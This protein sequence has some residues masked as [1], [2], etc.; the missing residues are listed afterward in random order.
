[1]GEAAPR[2]I[3]RCLTA[4]LVVFAHVMLVWIV[5]Q[6]RAPPM[7]HAEDATGPYVIA[8]L[9]DQPRPRNL[10]LG[11]TPIQVKTQ[12]VLHLQKLAPRVPDIPIDLSEPTIAE[13]TVPLPISSPTVQQSETGVAGEA[14]ES[15]A[16]SGG[17]HALTLIKRV[18]PKYPQASA[19]L[20]EQGNTA[21]RIRVDESGS[22]TDAKVTH[23]S[24]SRRLD[25]AA[26]AA[27]RKWKYAPS[28]R[29]SGPNGWWIQTELRFVLYQFTYSRI[30]DTAAE[31][32]YGEQVKAG[33]KDEATPGSQEAVARFIAEVKGG[34]FT[35]EPD[36]SVRDDVARLRT[37]LQ[38]WGEVLSIQF[39]GTAGARR[40]MA[41]PVSGVSGAAQARPTV[42]VSWNMFE[43]RHRHGTSA[44]LIAV[45]RDGTIWN[46]RASPAPWL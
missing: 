27:V 32:V 11:P 24:G 8:S 38:E 17:G 33:E 18:V 2:R 41:Y 36:T 42:E 45:D 6:L 31:R 1:M 40:W 34:V 25:S 14:P 44:W 7:P 23:S 19:D 35:G 3:K 12:D 26:L 39:I 20:Q 9:I 21:V 16:I 13:E 22:V 46:A 15:T 4:G 43:V 28:P 29:G 30:G 37:A 5:I 10:T